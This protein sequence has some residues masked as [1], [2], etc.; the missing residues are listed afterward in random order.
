MKGLC[1]FHDERS[2]SFHVRA[3][4]RASTTASAAASRGDVLLVPAE[5]GPRHASPRPS[6]GWPARIGLQLHYEDGGGDARPRQPRP[7]ARRQRGRR[8]VLRRAAA[9][10][11]RPS[12]A[13][14]SS[15]SAASTPAP[16]RT[17][18]SA[19][20]PRAGTSSTKHLRAQGFTDDELTAAGLV[21]QRRA[22]AST[23]GSAA[24]LVWPIRDVTGQTVGFGARKLLDDDKGPKYLN[25]PETPR[26]P[27]GPGALRARPRQARHLPQPRRSSSSRATPTSWPATSPAS[28]PPSPPAAPRSASTTSRSLRRV[29]G[30]DSTARRG[31]LHL[32]PGC[33]GPEGRDARVRRGAAL[34]RADLRRR[35][36]RRP[37]PVRPAHSSRGDDAVRRLVDD[38]APMFE[39][40]HR[41]AA[42][43]ATTSTPSRAGS[44]RCA[45]PRR[46]SPTSA[47]RSCSRSTSACSRAGSAWTPRMSGARSSAPAAARGMRP[48]PPSNRSATTPTARRSSA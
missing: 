30:D 29:L 8:G 35:R 41:P 48:R 17:S 31:H 44:P 27:Q 4:G 20:P 36:A 47:T 23:T 40:V 9:A 46:S 32:R 43:A 2:P 14:A 5:D 1:P 16:P 7:P 25:T 38:E 12:S 33:R 18:A 24:A 28:R 45:R 3:A 22:A 39:F 34:R 42:R 10:P 19:S 11:R 15:A 37:R 21:S 6:S 13:A 26:L